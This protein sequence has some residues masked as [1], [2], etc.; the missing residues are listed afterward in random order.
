MSTTISA[1]ADLETVCKALAAKQPIDPEVL[2][3]IEERRR[4]SSRP[5]FEH[6]MSLELLREARF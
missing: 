4:E 5:R 3:R 1:A 6:E 2:R